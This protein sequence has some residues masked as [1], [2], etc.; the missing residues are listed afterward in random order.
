MRS[1]L[2]LLYCCV[3]AACASYQA[4][5][6]ATGISSQD[7]IPH[8]VVDPGTMPLPELAA[9]QFDPSD[10]LDMTELAILAVLNNPDLKIARDDVGI[11]KAQ[12][13]SAGLLPDPQL[14]LSRDLSNSG[15]PGSTKAFSYGISYDLMAL[16]NRSTAVA[17][18][19][20]ETRKTDL[21]LLWQE[22]QV[23]SQA[24]LLYVKL[25]QGLKAKAVLEQNRGL[26]A[27]RLHRTRMAQEKGL[28]TSDAVMPNLTALQDVQ[29]QLNDLERQASQNRHELNAL[30]GLAPQVPVTLQDRA[31]PPE[32]DDAAVLEVLPK[33]AHRRPDLMGLEAGY[34][35]QDQRYRAAILAQFPSLNLGLT[36][37]RDSSGIYSNAVGLSLS[38]PILNRNRGNI[39]VEDATRQK[40]Q[41]EYQQ[42]L[43]TANSDIHKIL[44]EQRINARQLQEIRNGLVQLSAAAVQADKAF[45]Q[46]NID[47]LIYANVHTALL[48]KQIEEINLQ[49]TMLEQRVA[50]MTLIGGELPVANSSENNKR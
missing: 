29:K 30:L 21:N 5:P 23:V 15:G 19:Q 33:L 10:G 48:N 31:E 20:A 45:L 37:A 43:N 17:A 11:A 40:L 49:E 28:L 27:D 35:A 39:A 32:V 2:P 4:R 1:Y 24:R 50:L 42:R 3:L 46:K 16:V 12:A 44:A 6:L 41:D 13:F 47:S 36:H 25:T 18:A 14:S 22:W 9:H 7:K 26:F 38:L 8:L 34:L